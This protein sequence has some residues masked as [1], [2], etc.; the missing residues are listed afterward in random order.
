M[1]KEIKFCSALAEYIKGML[2]EKRACGYKYLTEERILLR[3]DAYWAENNKDTTELTM[4]SLDG[5]CQ[6]RNNEGSGNYRNRISP[7]SELAKYMNG[8]G[9]PSYIPD[10]D[11]TVEPPVRHILSQPERKEFFQKVDEYR[12]KRWAH[13]CYVRMANEYP[14]I[15]RLI[16][17]CGLRIS[18]ACSLPLS[19]VDLD[20]G[21]ITILNAKGDKNRLVYMTNDLTEAFRDYLTYMRRSLSIEP[22]WLF[23]G[24]NPDQ[25]ISPSGVTTVF[26]ICWSRTSFAA[27][28]SKKPT[29][30][31]LRHTYATDRINMWAKQ[32]LSFD[33]MLPYLCKAMGHKTF[34]E[35]FYYVH[36]TL[37]SAKVIL[38]KDTTAKKVIPE[39]KRR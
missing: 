14:M 11:I 4:E 21:V 3:F 6:I 30:H 26:N 37:E 36:F 15:F 27:T 31:D 19:Q 1:A 35:T 2:E 20:K 38:E 12:P 5:W 8:L 17:L 16:Y 13:G 33:E 24:M 7:V 39:V 32:G 9:I 18:E 22:T 25:H 23:P 29:V 10:P 34:K 28:C